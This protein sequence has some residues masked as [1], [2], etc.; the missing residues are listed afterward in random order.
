MGLS[1]GFPSSYNSTATAFIVPLTRAFGWGRTIPSL[2]YFAGMVGLTL[3]SLGLGYVIERFG[4]ARVSALSG[5]AL[6][7]LLSLLG[8][9]NGASALSIT[10]CFLAGMLGAGTGVGL[11]LAALPTYFDRHLG[12]ALGIAAV[13]QSAG[14]AFLPS[15]AARLIVSHGWRTAYV[16]IALLQL[17][18][19]LLAAALLAWAA[20]RARD[21]RQVVAVVPAIGWSL[22]EALRTRSFWLLGMAI[23]LTSAGV[24]GAS[25]H[26]FPIYLDRGIAPARL[27]LVALGMGLGTVIGRLA[28]GLLLDKVRPRFVAATTMTLGAGGLCWLALP[29][30]DLPLLAVMGPPVLVNLALGAESDILAYFV[31][32]LFGTL[33]FPAIY[34]RLLTAFYMGAVAGTL[35]LG[36]AADHGMGTGS[37]LLVLA[38]GVF[39][40]AGI[41]LTLVSADGATDDLAFDRHGAI[42][43]E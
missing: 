41:A 36:V 29:G 30:G 39:A 9:Q 20:R 19:T 6:A 25:I 14:L 34:N 4:A 8:L 38:L 3:G 43:K 18:V 32:R 7:V 11:Y 21:E 1:V 40:A 27:P 12:R 35:F 24:V 42:A 37:A 31:R 13:G 17:V 22:E 2:M 16:S 28:S 5:V 23:F 33:H 26:I 10:L 15:L